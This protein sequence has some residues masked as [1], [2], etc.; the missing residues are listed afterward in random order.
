MGMLIIAFN[1]HSG[2][3]FSV[4]IERPQI[5]HPFQDL[6]ILCVSNILYRIHRRTFFLPKR[7][8]KLIEYRFETSN[9]TNFICFL[10]SISY[11]RESSQSSMDI[12]NIFSHRKRGGL[13]KWNHT[14]F[15]CRWGSLSLISKVPNT[16][17]T[18]TLKLFVFSF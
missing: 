16:V 13:L 2:A 3:A 12:R 6:L 9:A 10:I 8:G 11:N 5:H 1:L 4:S 17:F 18:D 15:I 14:N 7:R